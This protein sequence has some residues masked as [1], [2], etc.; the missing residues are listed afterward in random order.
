MADTQGDIL[1]KY[2]HISHYDPWYAS[3]L[4]FM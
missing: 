4:W 2:I 1:P 3:V